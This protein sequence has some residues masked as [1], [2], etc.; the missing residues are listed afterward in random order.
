VLAEI[1]G[2]P[3]YKTEVPAELDNVRIGDIAVIE[4]GVNAGFYK[5]IE[6]SGA[7]IIVDKSPAGASG[8]PE[9]SAVTIF[10]PVGFSIPAVETTLSDTVTIPLSKA[11][12]M[13]HVAPGRVLVINGQAHE[14]TRVAV[15]VNQPEPL[16]SISL[17]DK[18]LIPGLKGLS[19]RLPHT[20]V[21]ESQDFEALGVSPGDVLTV[22]VTSGAAS[23]D[24]PCQVVGAVG[25]R[26][27]FVLT[28]EPLVEGE[29]PGVPAR[30]LAAIAERFGINSVGSSPTGDLLISNE[31]AALKSQIGSI[32]FKRTYWNVELTPSSQFVVN[33]R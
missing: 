25:N 27:G 8:G 24:L 2:F 30:F 6:K 3:Y 9:S 5:I 33:G 28:D 17:R 1:Y 31:A 11:S 12:G 26:L 15:D 19:W 16:L 23:V 14:I 4:S 20:L 13:A 29:D 7:F 10:R 22:S 21:S 32:F 18:A